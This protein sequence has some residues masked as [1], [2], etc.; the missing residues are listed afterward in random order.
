MTAETTFHTASCTKLLT[1]ISILQCVERGQL[2]LDDDISKYLDEW[3]E[4]DLLVGFDEQSGEPIL[5]KAQK[6][7][8]IHHL[9]TH[10]WGNA[11]DLASP[12]IQKWKKWNNKTLGAAD[13]SVVSDSGQ[14]QTS[15]LIQSLK[16]TRF[17]SP[18]LFEAG[19]GWV[20][21]G[22][23]DWSGQIIERIHG[24]IRLGDYMKKHIFE[25]LKMESSGFRPSENARIRDHLCATTIRTSTGA[26]ENGKPFAPE[27]PVHDQGGGGLYSSATDYLKVLVSLLMNDGTLLKPDTVEMMFTPQLSDP[28]HLLAVVNPTR[29]IAFRGGVESEA[30]NWGYGGMLNGEDVEGLCKKGT[31]TWG[32][33]PNL[34]WVSGISISFLKIV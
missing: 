16:F 30:W 12:T 32:G 13:G 23:L 17:L 27:D 19:D 29:A 22:G 11:N 28:K 4:P 24:G 33:L 3:K 1:T 25:P 5:H 8:T 15:M 20:Y 34:F 18:L 31:M 21:G 2:T 26:L 6:K 14:A 7:I 9:L 10:S